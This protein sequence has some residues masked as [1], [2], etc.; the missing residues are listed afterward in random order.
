M[1]DTTLI[2]KSVKSVLSDKLL[3]MYNDKRTST[4]VKLFVENE[5]YLKSMMNLSGY[6]ELDFFCGAFEVA[7]NVEMM[8]RMEVAD[9]LPSDKTELFRLIKD[10]VKARI[11][12]TLSKVPDE[13][14][15]ESFNIAA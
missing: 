10:E 13:M 2:K 3:S 14:K 8:A 12:E 9:A 15:K 4:F 7:K 1:Y 11:A 6:G 5:L